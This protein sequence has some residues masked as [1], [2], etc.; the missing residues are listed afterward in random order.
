VGSP[1][2]L[3]EVAVGDTNSFVRPRAAVTTACVVDKNGQKWRYIVEPITCSQQVGAGA[4]SFLPM[5]L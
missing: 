5:D 3:F 1:V 4:F 2:M